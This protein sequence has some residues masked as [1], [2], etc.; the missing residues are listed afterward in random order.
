MLPLSLAWLSLLLV[1]SII[2]IANTCIF[3]IY[4]RAQEDAYTYSELLITFFGR[5][6]HISWLYCF[7]V[8]LVFGCTIWSEKHADTGYEI[9][10]ELYSGFGCIVI[11]TTC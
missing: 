3:G 7:W 2:Q 9:L 5:F 10:R 1:F 4:H 11:H 6:L 8:C